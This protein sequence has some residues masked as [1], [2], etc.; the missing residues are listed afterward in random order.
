MSSAKGQAGLTLVETL[1]ALAILAAVSL[2]SFAMLSQSSRFAASEQDRLMASVLADNLIVEELA[3]AAPPE[4]G[5]TEGKSVFA[6]RN[7][8]WRRVATDAGLDLVGIRYDVS[9]ENETRILAK[10]EALK[11]SQ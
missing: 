3:S 7:F 4:K 10:S 6:G 1:V 2:A 9:L 8:V 11:V 5:A